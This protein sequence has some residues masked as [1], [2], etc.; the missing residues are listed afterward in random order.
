MEASGSMVGA[1]PPR[2]EGDS[3]DEDVG[4]GG[5]FGDESDDYDCTRTIE[6]CGHTI[7]VQEVPAGVDV[8]RNARRVWPGNQAVAEWLQTNVEALR[9]A[10]GVL[11]IGA[12]TGCLGGVAPRKKGHFLS[13]TP[14]GRPRRQAIVRWIHLANIR[15]CITKSGCSKQYP[16]VYIGSTSLEL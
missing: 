14:H 5:L 15:R 6:L 1:Q 10:N 16:W 9:A 7:K 3:S 4:C 13:Y 8:P 2:E 11:E 12:A